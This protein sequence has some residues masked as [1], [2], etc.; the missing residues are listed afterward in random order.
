VPETSL[1][2]RRFVGIGYVTM[3]DGR[4]A[5]QLILTEYSYTSNFHQEVS[6]PNRIC[7][8]FVHA[9][10]PAEERAVSAAIEAVTSGNEPRENPA[11]HWAAEHEIEPGLCVQA[12]RE[13][14][15]TLSNAA[16]GWSLRASGSGVTMKAARWQNPI[17]ETMIFSA[18]REVSR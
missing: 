11:Y 5:R 6:S 8:V 10:S 13:A 12:Q 2:G 15:G 18:E 1:N 7:A 9:R 4:Q 14:D 16:L 17:G 3:P